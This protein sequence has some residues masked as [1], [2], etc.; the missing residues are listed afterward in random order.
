MPVNED[1]MIFLQYDGYRNQIDSMGQHDHMVKLMCQY[2]P[3]KEKRGKI[4]V[5]DL[6]A[7]TGLVGEQLYPEGFKACTLYL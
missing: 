3:D 2:F 6:A 5:L 4:E 1:F 7:G